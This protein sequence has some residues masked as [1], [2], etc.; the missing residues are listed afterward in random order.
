MDYYKVS[1]RMQPE[2]IR[3]VMTVDGGI[4]TE[5]LPYPDYD[6]STFIPDM[7]L[8]KS[9]EIAKANL[10][11]YG[12]TKMEDAPTVPAPDVAGE[13]VKTNPSKQMAF[14]WAYISHD[15]YG[16]QV[17]DKSGDFVDDVEELEE[18]AYDFVLSSRQ[19]DADHTNVKS[20]DLVES[21]VFTP[22]KIRKLGIPDG[23]MP[24]GWWIGFK[25][26]DKDVWERVEKGELTMF[27]VHGTGTRTQ[28]TE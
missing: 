5:W 24:S 10:R 23:F 6:G 26:H 27:S 13:I 17:I 7:S 28:I 8:N 2:K 21:M 18:A 15:R 1:G 25:I 9:F 14:G 11:S 20:S 3:G 12:F 19:G 4:V 22:E 16:H